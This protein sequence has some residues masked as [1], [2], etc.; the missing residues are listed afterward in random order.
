MYQINFSH[1]SSIYFVGIGGVS[2]SGLAEILADAG[3]T[4]SGSDRSRS[5]L[6]NMLEAK[7]ITVFYGQR[8]QNITEDIDCVVFTSAIG[9]DNPEYIAAHERDI[10]CLTR[11]ELLG[12]IMKNYDMPIAVS[13]THG[14]TTTTSMLSEILLRADM[15]PTLSIGGILKTIGGN[16]RVGRSEYFVTEACEYTNSFLSFFPKIGVI[17]NIEEDHLDFFKDLADIRSSF[18]RFAKLLPKDGCLIINAGIPDWQEIAGGLACRVVTFGADA[19][20]DCYPSDIS[21]DEKGNPRFT[22]HHAD[23]SLTEIS[24]RVPG[25]HNILNAVAAAATA[26]LLSVDR[27]C[28]AQALHS[29]TGTDRRFEYKGAIGGVTVIDDYSHH[30]TEIAAA[31]NAAARYPHKT[32]WCVFQPHTYSRTK[33]FLKEFAQALTLADKVVLADI[34]AA[35]ETDTLGISSETLQQEVQALGKE[36]YYFPTFDEIENFLLENCLKGDLLIT[37]GAGDVVKIGETILGI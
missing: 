29:F 2:M 11:A 23:G 17:L 19:N 6:T 18:R 3:F 37:M 7:G 35:R 8:A 34:Y 36:C 21:Y 30:P 27:C 31:L 1:P 16:I 33:A 22:L 14:K 26:D 15:D 10:P 32:L 4:V 12:Q 28:T 5:A 24:L 13:G 25:E 20:A 9:R